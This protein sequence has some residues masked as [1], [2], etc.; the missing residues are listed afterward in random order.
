M[1]PVAAFD[2]FGLYEANQLLQQWGHRMGPLE[3]GNSSA[4]QCHA[5]FVHGKPVALACTSSLI[6][7]RVGGGLSH[8]TR[9]NTVELSRLCAGERWANRVA[10]RLW[11]ECV[12]PGTGATF[13]ISYQDADIHNGNTYRF[14]GWERAGFSSSGTDS[15]SGRSGRRKWIWVWPR[16]QRSATTRHGIE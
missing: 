2:S 10:L 8:M 13:A 7:E 11:R 3:R 15:R 14:D 5:L 16:S 4:Q 1:F 12:F 6:R 9:E